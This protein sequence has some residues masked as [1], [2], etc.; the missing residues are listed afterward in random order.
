[1]PDDDDLEALGLNMPV[2]AGASPATILL[3]NV[4]QR[5][6][7]LRAKVGQSKAFATLQA[8][9]MGNLGTITATQS[10]L[11]QCINIALR[12]EEFRKSETAVSK[13][14]TELFSDWLRAEDKKDK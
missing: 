5:F 1:M 3:N 2:P 14:A 13:T 9:V 12:I 6:V 4:G 10:S 11:E 7:E 8:G